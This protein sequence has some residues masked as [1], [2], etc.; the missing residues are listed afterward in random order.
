MN[1]SLG[2]A[3]F[4]LYVTYLYELYAVFHIFYLIFEIKKNPY[5]ISTYVNSITF[6]IFLVFYVIV[7]MLDN[8]IYM[9][10]I[11]YKIFFYT[12][13]FQQT[14]VLLKIIVFFIHIIQYKSIHFDKNTMFN[15]LI[16]YIIPNVFIWFNA[17]KSFKVKKETFYDI[18]IYYTMLFLLRLH[19]LL[20][21]LIY[22]VICVLLAFYYY[23]LNVRK[24]ST[25]S[26]KTNKIK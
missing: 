26:K 7:R 11:F 17:H 24:E 13:L 9:D 19:S 22:L 6:S 21:T 25:N 23:C 18:V 1:K 14:E 16:F 12:K 4:N 5:N 15:L 3:C 20:S 2:S 10:E 8:L